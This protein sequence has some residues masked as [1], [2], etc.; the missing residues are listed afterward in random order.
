MTTGKAVVIGK[1]HDKECAICMLLD[2]ENPE[3]EFHPYKVNIVTGTYTHVC[4]DCV[5]GIKEIRKKCHIIE[6]F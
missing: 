2:V 6:Q 5:E 3:M 1:R 4:N